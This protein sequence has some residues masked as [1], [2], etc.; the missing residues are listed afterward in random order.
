MIEAQ[1]SESAGV[2]ER[3]ACA[4]DSLFEY[5]DG[6]GLTVFLNFAFYLFEEHT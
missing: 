1:R 6:D 4:L 5:L 2:R 3:V